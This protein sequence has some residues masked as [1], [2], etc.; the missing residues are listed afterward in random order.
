MRAFWRGRL[1]GGFQ[2]FWAGLIS[3][4]DVL[5]EI[6]ECLL[7]NIDFAASSFYSS[8]LGFGQFQDVA[9]HGILRCKRRESLY[10]QFNKYLGKTYEEDSDSWRR[11]VGCQS[12]IPSNI[13][14]R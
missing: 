9:V 4:V 6:S 12:I 13:E 10:A 3:F 14:N 5:D 11:H 8:S 7:V 2:R 1:L